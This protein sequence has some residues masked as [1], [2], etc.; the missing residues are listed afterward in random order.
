MNSPISAFKKIKEDF[1]RYYDTAYHVN[2]PQVQA[3]N[4]ALLNR[5]GVLA[6]SPYIEP[7][8]EYQEFS[9][10][11]KPVK[12]KDLTREMLGL[13]DKDITESQ[14]KL[15]KEFA[16]V[17]L[18]GK[19][20]HLYSHQA[21]MLKEALKGNNCVVT[22]GTGSGKTES[23]LLP[24]FAQL[25]K[26]MSKW[27]P[28]NPRRTSNIVSLL[29]Q[30]RNNFTT[31]GE[32]KAKFVKAIADKDGKLTENARQR[33]TLDQGTHKPAI[34][35]LLIYPMNALVEDQ[36]RRLRKALDNHGFDPE[37]NMTATNESD[38]FYSE[39]T[40]NNRIYFGRYNGVTPV[41]G[42]LKDKKKVQDLYKKLS[43]IDSNYRKVEKYVKEVLPNDEDFKSLSNDDKKEAIQEILGF[44]PRLDGTEMY[45]RQDMQL[46]P[47]DI[48]ITNFSMLN[49]MMMRKVEDS[50]FDKTRE[51]LDKDEQNTFYIIV[52][53]LH[54]NRGTA[55]TEQAYLLRLLYNR[56]GRSPKTSKQI[57]ILASSA[58]L[59]DDAD[60]RKFLSDFF[61]IPKDQFVIVPGKN[62]SI[63]KEQYEGKLSPDL[64]VN[65]SEQWQK[66][67]SPDENNLSKGFE[68]MCRQILSQAN[69]KMASV[70][71]PVKGI[72]NYCKTLKLR[73]R[74]DDAFTF[75]EGDNKKQ[76][77]IVAYG[78]GQSGRS[79]SNALFGN[80]GEKAADAVDGLFIIRL[81]MG[82]KTYS[83]EYGKYLPRFRSHMFFRN[84]K[85]L[86]ASL[87]ANDVDKDFKS[88]D[89]KIGR[90]YSHP[91]SR[92]EA[93]NRVLEVL[94]C[95]HCGAIFL[96]GYR[97]KVSTVKDDLGDDKV[98]W[99]LLPE[100]S[101]L[102][103]CPMGQVS[104][105]VYYRTYRQ[106][107]V[108]WPGK[109][110]D[111]VNHSDIK[112]GEE[113]NPKFRWNGVSK[114]N[115]DENDKLDGRW[116]TAWLDKKSGRLFIPASP[117]D[118][119]SD[120]ER[121]IEGQLYQVL[122]GQDVDIA[123][124]KSSKENEDI[125]ALPHTCPACG[126]NLQPYFKQNNTRRRRSP[127]RSFHAGASKSSQIL[128]DEM[129]KLLPANP[130]K[131]KLVAFSDSR[132]GA[133]RL[134]A[135]VEEN[136]FNEM[137][138]EVVGIEY[139][140]AFK[141]LKQ[142][143]RNREIYQEMLAGKTS[144]DYSGDD[145]LIAFDI[146]DALRYK[147]R[148]QLDHKIGNT[149]TT[150]EVYLGLLQNPKVT[151][152]NLHDFLANSDQLTDYM[153]EFISLGVNPSGV[154]NSCQYI[155]N[156]Q[157]GT[158]NVKWTD[159]ID[160]PNLE[161]SNIYQKEWRR[162]LDENVVTAF[163]KD[164]SGRLFYSFESTGLGY[165][166]LDSTSKNLRKWIEQH[167]HLNATTDEII[168]ICDACIR[169][170]MELYKHD[171]SD[172]A[173][174][175]NSNMN[176]S[177]A[178]K[179]KEDG[180]HWPRKVRRWISNVATF[181]KWKYEDL[182]ALIFGIFTDKEAS[183]ILDDYFGIRLD[184]LFF[185]FVPEDGPVWWNS[186]TNIPHLHKGGGICCYEGRNR[187]LANLHD[188]RM[189]LVKAPRKV[190]D[191]WDN[192]YLSYYTMVEHQKP[193]RMH[194]EEMTGQT[195]DQFE[196]QR[197][198][199]NIILDDDKE[200]KQVEQIDLLSVTTTLEV[201]VDIG[202]LQSVLL[203][204]MPPQRFNYQQRVGRAGRRGQAFSYV[205][206]YCKDKSHDSFYFEHPEKITGD[207]CPTPFLAMGN[208]NYDI[209]KR[210]IAKEVL[211]EFFKTQDTANI[212]DI[213]GEFGEL[214]S[215]VPVASNS[216][217]KVDVD[218]WKTTY[219]PALIKWL[220]GNKD[221]NAALTEKIY[222]KH[223]QELIAWLTPDQNDECG[224]INRMDAILEYSTL[225]GNMI[226]TRLAQGGLLPMYGMPSNLKSFYT[227]D[228]ALA[229]IDKPSEKQKGIIQRNADM[230]IYE[231]APGSQKTKDKK[232]YTSAGFAPAV[233]HKEPF[234]AR[235]L[236]RCP[237]C[238]HIT[239][240]D[241]SGDFP[242]N[243]PYCHEPAQDQYKKRVVLPYGY[244]GTLKPSDSLDDM[245][246]FTQ[247]APALAEDAKDTDS[248]ED[249]F[250][251]H[252]TLADQSLTWKVNT[253]N[254]EGYKGKYVEYF[255]KTNGQL[256]KAKEL[257]V[258]DQ[259]DKTDRSPKQDVLDTLPDQV[260]NV[261]IASSKSTNVLYVKLLN[262]RKNLCT[263]AFGIDESNHPGA[264][265]AIKA[266][267][268]SAAN[269]IQRALASS[270]DINPEEIELANLQDIFLSD[271]KHSAE[272]IFN[273]QLVN[274]SG[275]VR[276]LY[277][278]EFNK[279]LTPLR[280]P[281]KPQ[282]DFI[283]QLFVDDHIRTCETSCYKCLN[284]YMNMAYHP[285]LDWRLGISLLRMLADNQYRCGSDGVFE[286]YPELSYYIPGV[287]K[288][289]TWL[290]ESKYLANEFKVNYMTS[291]TVRNTQ[292][293]E[294]GLWYLQDGDR[295]YVIVHPL[296]DTTAESEWLGGQLAHFDNLN[297]GN[298]KFL[299]TFNLMRRQSWCFMKLNEE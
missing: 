225:D 147:K 87:D 74:I 257:W 131:R 200:I 117:G 129:M 43:D 25:A 101:E 198:F 268:Y 250:N 229:S 155:S 7:M 135:G 134:S 72:L 89:R 26:E 217:K 204:D 17:G 245:P 181:H 265:I 61:D 231:F 111:M 52:D 163:V 294:K 270:L 195:D 246:V 226:A 184:M 215:E 113:A 185:Q 49:I 192:N 161:W 160:F 167:N 75:G 103:N 83:K 48:M 274:G 214:I 297:T 78:E 54:L 30:D 287:D 286:G 93:G 175:N 36:I 119:P 68:F 256:G 64:F 123:D 282:N 90:L 291:A 191:L 57:R 5:D 216:D 178:S 202:S 170:W 190:K 109:K 104:E 221:S 73:E 187:E 259:W 146:E 196:R 258:D 205:L 144:D 186:I 264:Q 241:N 209:V 194:C 251:M 71:D 63:A 98:E 45:S 249:L 53:E 243:C 165:F 12:F 267:F 100:S 96:G 82:N 238:N 292:S 86:W 278:K 193:M 208:D 44:F 284:V 69:P 65:V 212:N 203:A 20:Y 77:A 279:M 95:E 162:A 99:G 4:D 240:V 56:L 141:E 179:Y 37:N 112:S 219:R 60:G 189:V 94:Y 158:K 50:I 244:V 271:G 266:A 269:I 76:R 122:N 110:E 224:L 150:T 233:G 40:D 281:S 153:K 277:E 182:L 272:M 164:L 206:T 59:N 21:T 285:V 136:H 159:L 19:D 116:I 66:N 166:C 172:E 32:L 16:Y 140:K 6:R 260:E 290:E 236:Y 85:G 177:F 39:K 222:G 296:W 126:T 18:F 220:K 115:G 9:F 255:P 102:E 149:N 261:C 106:Y 232:V 105:D 180:A 210:I 91:I 207:P 173:G 293:D 138:R 169:V 58:S 47:P 23:F 152:F 11:G 130:S 124:L 137:I 201:G 298:V 51:W 139:R 252:L 3:E 28:A 145:Q 42:S 97:S 171:H 127:I 168:D 107:G 70:T 197:H 248:Q 41:A 46:T 156:G 151:P 262:Q 38:C 67:P 1:I 242:A 22:S 235:Y 227:T 2:I 239:I 120:E 92:T 273:D 24:L 283:G 55:G 223:V 33:P 114:I 80:I 121:Y 234:V 84:T 125:L 199:R 154:L 8:P 10:D 27:V 34:R 299:D 29:S 213:N 142:N 81:L 13:E 143:Q 132:E 14:W 188:E 148:G 211:C 230:A 183:N 62:K 176:N 118:K 157:V 295:V 88:N 288:V 237:K 276:E 35:A 174:S 79:L 15:F 228:E 128:A 253:N 280:D 108:F 254:D 133:A 289:Q 275:F 263:D 218:N 247:R 31:T